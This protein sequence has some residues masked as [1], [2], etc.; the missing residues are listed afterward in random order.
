MPERGEQS[1]NTGDSDAGSK[2][3]KSNFTKNKLW[4][5][6]IKRAVLADDGKKLRSIAEALIRKAEQG[7][8]SALKELGDRIDGKVVRETEA[9]DDKNIT[10]QIVKFEDTKFGKKS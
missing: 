9:N 1:F 10:V 3:G 8:V 7:D 6:V 4:R 5:D 2:K